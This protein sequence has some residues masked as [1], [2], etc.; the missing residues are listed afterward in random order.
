MPL[1]PAL[2]FLAGA[3]SADITSS[4]TA[5]INRSSAIA[6][7]ADLDGAAYTVT[8]DSRS[9]RLNDRPVLLLS[10]S[11]HYPRSTP[12]MWPALFAE[13]R[14]NGLNTIEVYVRICCPCCCCRRM[15]CHRFC[16]LLRIATNAAVLSPPSIHTA[17]LSGI[18][19]SVTTAAAMTTAAA[20][21]WRA[22]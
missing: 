16:C 15:P 12:A 10:G 21:T 13:V 7:Y 8:W 18:F 5:M 19:T 6:D 9:M 2:L 1:L 22:S 17:T 14:A 20:A 3:S 11:I 4:T